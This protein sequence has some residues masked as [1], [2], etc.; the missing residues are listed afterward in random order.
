MPS[1]RRADILGGNPVEEERS[2]RGRVPWP[3][4]RIRVCEHPLG[5]SGRKAGR[6]EPQE[7]HDPKKRVH[8]RDATCSSRGVCAGL[9]SRV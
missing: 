3:V 8:R 1:D 6:V 4:E 9:K 7:G 2:I 5:G